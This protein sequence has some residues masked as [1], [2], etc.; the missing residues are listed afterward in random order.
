MKHISTVLRDMGWDRKL[1]YLA[2][3]VETNVP[4]GRDP[5]RFHVEKGEISDELK[6]MSEGGR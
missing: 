2:R 3:R 4:D 1:K 6:R 5:E